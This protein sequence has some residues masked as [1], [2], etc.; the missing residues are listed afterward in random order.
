M[1]KPWTSCLITSFTLAWRETYFYSQC[2]RLSLIHISPYITRFT[3]SSRDPDEIDTPHLFIKHRS[4]TFEIL[5]T[6]L[7][8]NVQNIR[9]C[10]GEKQLFLSGAHRQSVKYIRMWKDLNKNLLTSVKLCISPSFPCGF[11][12]DVW[13]FDYRRKARKTNLCNVGCEE[14]K[15]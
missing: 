11:R 2:L 1:F 7:L 3:P 8:R 14:A 6:V 10:M 4:P 9:V 12:T 13:P 5:Q 15:A